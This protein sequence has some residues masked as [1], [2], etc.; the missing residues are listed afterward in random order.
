MASIGKIDTEALVAAYRPAFNISLPEHVQAGLRQVLA[1]INADAT[2]TDPRR[3]AYVLATIKHECGE[4]WQPIEEWGRG[5]G[6]SYGTPV[7]VTDPSSGESRDVVYDGR[8]YVQLTWQENYRRFD[9]LLGLN[10]R[11]WLHPETAMIPDISW[12]ICSLGMQ[13]GLFTGKGLDDYIA[14]PV[15]DFIGARRII[16]GQARAQLI[17]GYAH[18]FEDMLEGCVAEASA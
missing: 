1:F 5:A 3:I 17:A 4:T 16:N 18:A 9:T 13:R 15:C 8:G 2:L 11:L 14:G 10:N 12:K 6:H 7:R